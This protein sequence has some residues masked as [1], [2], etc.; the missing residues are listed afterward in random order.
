MEKIRV[1]L[2]D[3]H[4]VVRN[5]IK[6]LIDGSEIEIIGEANNGVE[7]IETVKKLSPDV[8]LMDISMPQMNGLDATEIISK[9]YK[10]SKS[11]ILS[12]YDNEEYILSAVEVG[13]LGYLLKDAPREE[14]LTAIRTV[15]KGEKY[16][17]SSVSNII[18]NGYLKVKK[19]GA[20]ETTNLVKLSK[21][22]MIILKQ[23]VEGLNSRQIADKL[24]LS[25]RTVDNH[26]ANMMKKLSVKNAAELVKLAIERKM[27]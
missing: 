2:A 13:A 3:D 6:T 9:Q 5:G 20:P 10:N 21:K 23:I 12:M 11:L 8:V 18:I 7:A 24:E 19:S 27:L 22:E 25:I 1:V 15:A 26:R 16:F 14:I 17:N 4:F